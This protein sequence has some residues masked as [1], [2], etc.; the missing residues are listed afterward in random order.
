MSRPLLRIK[1]LECKELVGRG[2]SI[3]IYLIGEGRRVAG[4]RT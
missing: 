4:V 2:C 3:G 1:L